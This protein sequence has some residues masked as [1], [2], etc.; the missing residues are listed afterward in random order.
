MAKGH[1]YEQT[2]SLNRS[3]TRKPL[4]EPAITARF[5]QEDSGLK[6]TKLAA[7]QYTRPQ[8]VVQPTSPSLMARGSALISHSRFV[9]AERSMQVS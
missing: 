5:I 8:K 3:S 1:C 9:A 2:L 7:G 6:T 4:G